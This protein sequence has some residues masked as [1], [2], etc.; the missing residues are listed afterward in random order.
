MT[1][2]YKP[3]YVLPAATFATLLLVSGGIGG[4]TK[5]TPVKL[6]G[7][8]AYKKQ[9]APCHGAKG[10]GTKL[11][12]MALTGGRSVG[13]L[14]KYISQNMPPGPK[15]CKS[16]DAK[17]ISSFIFDAFYSP[18]AYAKNSPARISLSR[19]TVR[20]FRNSVCDLI[21]SFRPPVQID[22][23]HGLSAEYF[24]TGRLRVGDRVL[25]RIDPEVKFDFGVKSP[26]P[27]Q[28]DP[29]QFAMLWQGSV[30]AE[31]TGE[32]EFIVRSEHGVSL[33]INDPKIPII[34]AQVKSGGD[35]EYRASLYLIGGRAYPL[36]LEFSKGV[37]GVENLEKLKLK[38]VAPATISLE[39][40]RP[41]Q[42]VEAIPE[43]CLIP[44]VNQV[45]FAPSNAFPPDDRSIGYERGTSVSK[46][47]DE[48]TTSAGL[49]T[50]AYI[51]KNLTELSGVPEDAKDRELRLKEFCRK[52][53][54]RAFKR[55]L[56]PDLEQLY[57]G[58]QF[59]SG[60]EPSLAVKRVALL[61]LKSPRFLY[62]EAG[63]KSPDAFDTASRLSYAIW[64]SLPDPELLKATGSGNL[65]TREQ[66][67]NQAKRMIADPKSWAKLR[68]FLLQW[69][70][71]DLVPDIAKD[72]KLFPEFDPSVASDLRTSL[73]LML[74]KIA[75]S[76]KSDYRELLQ[77]DG[78]YLNG[79][80]A[81]IY[82]VKLPEN[83]P[84]Q[85][86]SLDPNERSGV[87]THPYLMSSF[88]YLKTSS[89]IHRGV[90]IV[91]NMLGRTLQPPPAA[92]VPLNADLLPNLTTRERVAMQTKS[93]PCNSC[94]DLINPLGFALEKY[95]AIG[96]VRLVENGKQIDCAG[97]Y[98]TRAGKLATFNGARELGSYLANSDEAHAA[99][100][101]KLFQHVV[102]QP[103]RAY[104][105]T[106][107]PELVTYFETNN[108]S[109]RKLMAEIVTRTALK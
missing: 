1:L 40:R 44:T 7:E 57:I 79:R 16:E 62:R 3:N 74:E 43:R 67:S 77:S 60:I 6:T 88:A 70:K 98:R 81:K 23:R 106:M 19:L 91:R 28:K 50:A 105:T 96:R 21:G 85:S 25:R 34:D 92:F 10:E 107:L 108:F 48:A 66:V 59:K 69:L 99:F 26:L 36:R 4:Q 30:I 35:N 24:S 37:Q 82:G 56:T 68:Q 78:L 61:T 51:A 63:E 87:L 90:M 41:K 55:P 83:A 86:V 80:L 17:R 18:I 33:W 103:V 93:A 89:P 11:Y 76:E 72:A 32:Y 73:E 15:K 101:E 38:P 31:E 9:C 109:I 27:E 46:A 102:K 8:A 97:S 53:V 47:W 22:T 2:D 104:G 5:L 54:E 45:V 39:W 12:Q 100:V 58:R 94:H 52:F 49:Q 14:T 64:D 42:A 20:Q 75:M 71:V 29:Y 95:D 84:F 13:E 65:A